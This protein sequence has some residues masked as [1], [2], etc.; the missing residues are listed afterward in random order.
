VGAFLG[1]VPVCR[2]FGGSVLKGGGSVLSGGGYCMEGG[3][4]GGFELCRK[5]ML[6]GFVSISQ[7]ICPPNQNQP[8]I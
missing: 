1:G 3:G 7:R 2:G 6:V 8:E 4:A 5:Q